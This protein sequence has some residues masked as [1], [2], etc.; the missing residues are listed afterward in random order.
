MDPRQAK[1]NFFTIKSKTKYTF[2]PLFQNLILTGLFLLSSLYAHPPCHVVLLSLE[3]QKSLTI[4]Y[5]CYRIHA[6]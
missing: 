6:A 1:S 5:D 2:I 4:Y 3:V